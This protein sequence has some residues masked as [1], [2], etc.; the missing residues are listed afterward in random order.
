M[1]PQHPDQGGVLNPYLRH[2]A[3]FLLGATLLAF[4][5]VLYGILR[6]VWRNILRAWLLAP[7]LS[8]PGGLGVLPS[9]IW[10]CP[11]ALLNS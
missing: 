7:F 9:R 1:G 3:L 10:S 2:P 11:R 5:P 8:P 4:S 6:K